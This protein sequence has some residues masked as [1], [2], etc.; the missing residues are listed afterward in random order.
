MKRKSKFIDIEDN[1]KEDD[2]ITIRDIP[3]DVIGYMMFNFLTP[4]DISMCFRSCK[5]FHALS[6][7][8]IRLTKGL[9][10][11]TLHH[12]VQTNDYELVKYSYRFHN[13]KHKNPLCVRLD[14]LLGLCIEAQ[15]IEIFKFLFTSYDLS[16]INISNHILGMLLIECCTYISSQDGG[17]DIIELLMQLVVF[18][19]IDMSTFVSDVSL[20]NNVII[21]R[22]EIM[23]ECVKYDR[24]C[25][26][27]YFKD[28]HDIR[29][30]LD[31]MLLAHS[32]KMKE[33]IQQNGV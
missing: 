31:L 22:N 32:D 23:Q 16:N 9:A 33:Y 25:V 21:V 17:K 15:Y 19:K 26:L 3:L 14:Q 20:F 13:L 1:D 10:T 2:K 7:T 28:K 27:D 29:P 24:F 6:D 5:L 18:R 30:S 8:E 11:R 12:A 4:K